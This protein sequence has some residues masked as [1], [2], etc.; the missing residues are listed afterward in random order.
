[1]KKGPGLFRLYLV[2]LYCPLLKVLLYPIIG[3]PNT[4]TTRIQWKRPHVREAQEVR[5]LLKV[6]GVTQG[7]WFELKGVGPPWTR[8]REDCW[9]ESSYSLMF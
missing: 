4:K 8:V 5:Q 3:I 6:G 2:K 1:M 9:N 7:G